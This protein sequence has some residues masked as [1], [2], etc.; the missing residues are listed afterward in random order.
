MTQGEGRDRWTARYAET[1]GQDKAASAWLLA[2]ALKLP[3]DAT[4]VDLA[5][6]RGRH[7][8]PLARQGR[9]VVLVDFVESALRQ[10]SVTVPGISAVAAD[11]WCLP[12]ADESLDAILIANFLERDLFPVYR[13]LLKPGGYLLYETYTLDNA[14]LVAEGRARAPRSPQYMLAPGELPVLVAPLEV[15]SF[16]EGFVEDDAGCRACASILARKVAGD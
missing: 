9:H 7:A 1:A 4:I 15:L 11:L 2:A 14:A 3:P 8:R 5:G 12:F 16:R 10:T 6:G 13:R